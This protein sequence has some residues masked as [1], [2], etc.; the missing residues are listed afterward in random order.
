MEWLNY[1][2]LLYFWTV[3]REGSITRA[4][5]VLHLAQ[6]TISTQLRKLERRMGGKLFEKSGRRLRLTDLGRLVYRYADE[7][8]A[9]GQ[10]LSQA[11]A[12]RPIGQPLEL[13]IGSTESL[14]KHVVH[15]VLAPAYLLAEP[16]RL[17]CREGPLDKLLLDLAAYDLDVVL[18][19]APAS[20]TGMRL[21]AFNHL[22]GEST[23]SI[24]GTEELAEKYRVGFPQ[25]LDGAPLLVPAQGTTFR[26]NWETWC[27]EQSLR[28]KIVGEFQ[29]SALLKV[30]GQDG[31]GLFASPTVISTEVCRQY[32][33]QTV[34]EISE[35]KEK[36]YAISVERRLKHPAVVE[37]SQLA[38]SKFF[39]P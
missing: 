12:G 21:K 31:R 15:H 28:P 23:I 36:Y 14:P 20:S 27:E 38:K 17:E 25:S 22:L 7:I 24:F 33:V 2:H 11:V 5:E 18:S 39:Q 26:R 19:D 13:V 6:P 30:F 37:I 8:Y 3:A 35:L 16:I 32:T 10:E 34:G 4:C 1:H 9:V 29:D